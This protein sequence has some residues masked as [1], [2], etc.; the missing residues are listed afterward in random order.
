MG[1]RTNSWGLTIAD[2]FCGARDLLEG[3]RAAGFQPVYAIDRDAHSCKTN[4]S[5]FGLTPEHPSVTAIKAG[6]VAGHDVDVVVGDP[7]CQ[8]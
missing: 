7:S 3:F 4:Q 2:L 1:T 6:D 5:N 8:T